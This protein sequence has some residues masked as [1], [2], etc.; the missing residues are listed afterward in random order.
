MASIRAM[1]WWQFYILPGIRA[2]Y[3]D[4]RSGEL[5]LLF[6]ALFLAVAAVTSVSLL[7]DRVQQALDNRSAQMHGGDLVVRSDRPF[8]DATLKQ[9]E[10]LGLDRSLAVSMSSMASSDEAMRLVS[11]RAV[12]TNYPLKGSIDIQGP[13]GDVITLQNGPINGEAWVDPQLATLLNLNIGDVLALGESEFLVAGLIAHEPDRSVQ[14]INFAPRVLIALDDLPATGLVGPGSRVHYRLSLAGPSAAVERFQH[15]LEP[16]LER[17]QSFV[18]PGSESPE[19]ERTLK[20][21]ENFLMLVSLLTVVVAAVAVALAARHFNR[22]HQ[23]GV[24]IMR[25][26]GASQRQCSGLFL[27]EFFLLALGAAT[28]GTVLAFAVQSVLV[29]V[30]AALLDVSLPA[31]SWRPIIYGFL[32]AFVLLAGFAYPPLAQLRHISPAVVLRRQVKRV[33]RGQALSYLPGLL[34]F[35]LFTLALADDWRSGGVVLLGFIVSLGVFALLSLGLLQILAS[36]RKRLAQHPHWRLVLAGLLRRRGLAVLQLSALATGLL[37]LLLLVVTRT[38]L[39]D[40]WRATIPDSAPNTFL[41]NI[42]ADQR[43]GVRDFLDQAGLQVPEAAP[44]VRA[45]IARINQ[46]EIKSDDYSDDRARGLIEREFNLSYLNQLPQ[47]NEIT[48]G[49]WLNPDKNEVSLEAGVAKTLG[50]GLGDEI[51][52]EVAGQ[53]VDVTVTSLREVKWDSF[54]VNFFAVLTEKALASA[55][56]TYITSFYLPPDKQELTNSLLKKF[57]NLTVFDVAALISQVRSLLSQAI[58]GVQ[59]LFLFTLSAATVVLITAFLAT[60][61][62]RIHEVAILRVLGARSMQLR[63]GLI[64]EL[65]LLGVFAGLF[66][67][68]AAWLIASALAYYVFEFRLAFS[69]TVWVLGPLAGVVCS[70]LAGWLALK[71]VLSTAPLAILRE[72]A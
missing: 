69:L 9:A 2:F 52:F 34:I 25:C 56:A 1:R 21:A 38:D 65:T 20:R 8:S 66:A 60:R 32:T 58:Q 57:P 61:Q 59:L 19:I 48:H 28:L 72:V 54:D 62:E 55:P 64:F 43:D 44:M 42:Q 30:A 36:L 5:T 35:Y 46:Q 53:A 45:R 37:V 23:V 39:L 24:A 40:G 67:A 49:R 14:F 70:W 18:L 41:I 31:A 6:A 3:R 4:T 11:L 7:A 22:R 15:W 10:T 68:G 17:S 47:S 71:G 12:D 13:E 26:L 27:T 33:L 63:Q 51:R 16:R 50:L 29:S